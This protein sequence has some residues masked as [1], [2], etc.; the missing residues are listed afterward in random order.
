M[1]RK[2]KASRKLTPP[3]SLLI[4]IGGGVLLV[5]TA[6]MVASGNNP[7]A[8]VTP[9][10]AVSNIQ[11]LPSP[12]ADIPYPEVERVSLGDAK[13]AFDAGEAVFID[14]RG[15]Q[16]YAMAHI[17]DALSIALSDLTIRMNELD[18]QQRIITY[19]T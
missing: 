19:C 5:I 12:Q 7:P 8:A 18:P 16:V 9:T 3:I 17:P 1:P 13:A 2:K 4:A 15:D 6:I 11:A 10:T 14:V